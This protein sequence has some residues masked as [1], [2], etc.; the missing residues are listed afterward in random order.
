MKWVTGNR[1]TSYVNQLPLLNII[2]ISMLLQLN[3]LMRTKLAES[4][5][6]KLVPP[7]DNE[8][9]GRLLATFKI[10]KRG[11]ENAGSKFFHRTC[12]LINRLGKYTDTSK[13]FGLKN[14]ILL[15][16]K[17]FVNER[18]SEYNRCTL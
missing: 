6:C 11:T 7:D 1:D 18:F 16:M 10:P 13:K 4:K 3:I 5:E 2:P 9:Q 17:K 14:R 12:R 15:V 8:D